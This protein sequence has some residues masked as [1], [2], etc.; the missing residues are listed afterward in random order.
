[1]CFCAL[2]FGVAQTPFLC[3]NTMIWPVD[4]YLRVNCL[5]GRALRVFF[6]FFKRNCL[7]S[8]FL[9]WGC[10]LV[11]LFF[12]FDFPS[13]LCGFLLFLGFLL[14][15]LDFLNGRRRRWLGDSSDLPAGTKTDFLIRSG[16]KN[17]CLQK[18]LGLVLPWCLFL[19]TLPTSLIHALA[20]T[21][22]LE[23]ASI[24]PG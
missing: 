18:A 19:I 8:G 21:S 16:E 1:M 5:R 17:T 9:L 22:A 7:W 15:L 13:L 14:D 11:L 12:L 23:T 2:L 10:L 3:Q 20:A 6:G 24:E 4:C